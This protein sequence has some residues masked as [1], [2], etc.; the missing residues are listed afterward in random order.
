MKR[1][2]IFLI[3]IVFTACT[4]GKAPVGDNV[5]KQPPTQ[6]EKW[7]GER[8]LAFEANWLLPQVGPQ[9]NLISTPNYLRIKGDSVFAELPFRGR[10]FNGFDPD[11]GGIIIKA[12]ME[13]FQLKRNENR[14]FTTM[15]F[16][17][18]G[19][20]TERYTINMIVYDS[21]NADVNV[22]SN[23][24]DQMRYRGRVQDLKTKSN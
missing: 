13:D 16:D 17:V 8:Q 3:T 14:A 2:L 4:G 20:R 22:N 11:G 21:R 7:I 15:N 1:S 9:I 10:R 23:Q 24:R 18:K 12:E 19:E 5:V 6:V